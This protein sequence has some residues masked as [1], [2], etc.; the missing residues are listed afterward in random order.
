MLERFF[1]IASWLWFLVVAGGTLAL[2][3]WLGQQFI[4]GWSGVIGGAVVTFLLVSWLL[5]VI[6]WGAPRFAAARADT[7]GPRLHEAPPSRVRY[8]GQEPPG[9]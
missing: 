3:A 6:P 7:D 1:W 8:H 2:G 4:G 5:P 9:S